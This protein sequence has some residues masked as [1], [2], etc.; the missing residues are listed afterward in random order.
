MEEAVKAVCLSAWERLSR[1]DEDE[2]SEFILYF[3]S[4]IPGLLRRYD[5]QRAPFEG[6]LA[7]SVKF[8]LKSFRARKARERYRRALPVDPEFWKGSCST[9]EGVTG[10]V[11][12]AEESMDLRSLEILKEAEGAYQKN[13]ERRH[14]AAFKRRLLYV[15]LK[16]SP[17]ASRETLAEMAR[18]LDVEREEIETLSAR[19]EEAYR[20]RE[21]RRRRLLETQNEIA[22]TLYVL[23]R[24][25]ASGL[26]EW[27]RCRVV[28]AIAELESRSKRLLDEIARIPTAVSNREIAR[29]LDVPKGSVDSGIFYVRKVVREMKEKERENSLPKG[30]QR[31]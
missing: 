26:P 3:H 6:Y 4:R 25:L 8:Q 27:R 9:L 19:L 2:R 11:S 23:R 31:S 1:L 18:F 28:R 10:P 13:N 16:C 24:E 21:Q 20:A 30:E 17:Y 22:C 12:L 5:P 14:A 7:I 29:V 15:A